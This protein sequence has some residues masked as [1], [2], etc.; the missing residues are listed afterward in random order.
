MAMQM[1]GFRQFFMNHLLYRGLCYVELLNRCSSKS[2][3]GMPKILLLTNFTK[4]YTA[5]GRAVEY[6]E[7]TSKVE[8]CKAHM[9]FQTEMY[10]TKVLGKK[11]PI[12]DV[13]ACIL[14]IV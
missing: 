10:G 4:L 13:R 3:Q 1:Q 12:E 9:F 5:C 7:Y 6:T 2:H 14:T 8:G 11:S